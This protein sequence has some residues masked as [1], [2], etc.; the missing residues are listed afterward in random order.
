MS[1]FS[2]RSYEKELMDDLNAE[3]E[4][5]TQTLKELKIINKLL[6]GNNVTTSALESVIKKYP[7]SSYTIADV[8]C[9]G[10]DM[11]RIM[12]K[13]AKEKNV[14]C[15][16]IGID[17]NPNI[18]QAAEKNLKDLSNVK[19]VCQNVFDRN[20]LQ[21]K[22]DIITCT[23]FTH[24]FTDEEL[25][26]MFQNFKESTG[27]AMVIN[28]L[29]RNPLAYYSISLLTQLFSKSTMVKNDGPLS[30]LRSFRRKELENL[31]K[32]SGFHRFDLDWKWAFRW[33]AVAFSQES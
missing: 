4:V 32:T 17:A 25:I 10:G 13:W 6:G 31:I 22:V 19:F 12:A 28:D 20:F 30:V 5:L 23:L 8:G 11:I 14:D 24:H 2:N 3:G 29:H 9:G 16:F 7:K 15:Q 27:I 33:R 21:E 26:L 18:I 1:K